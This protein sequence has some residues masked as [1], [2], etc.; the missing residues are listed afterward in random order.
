MEIST[1][2]FESP[3]DGLTFDTYAR[4]LSWFTLQV[5]PKKTLYTDQ[6]VSNRIRNM[7]ACVEKY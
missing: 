5:R 6:V 3:S 1:I 7:D 4:D 2:I